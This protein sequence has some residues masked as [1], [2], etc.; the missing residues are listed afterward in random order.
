M[1]KI[2]VSPIQI[3]SDSSNLISSQV[4]ANRIVG[5]VSRAHKGAD[6]AVPTGTP[7]SAIGD[8]KVVFS[9]LHTSK[10]GPSH[11]FGNFVVVEHVINGQVYQSRYAHLSA[12]DVKVGDVV[13][14]GDV[15]GKSGGE[16]G[17]EA[18]GFSTGPHLHLELRKAKEGYNPL[19]KTSD[20]DKLNPND[21][22]DYKQFNLKQKVEKLDGQYELEFRG[23]LGVDD[24]SVLGDQLFIGDESISGT[25]T[26]L[27]DPNSPS[28]G[29]HTWKLTT[30]AYKKEYILTRLNE[31]NKPSITGTKLLISLIDQGLDVDGNKITTTENCVIINNFPFDLSFKSADEASLNNYDE[32]RT[33]IPAPFGIRLGYQKDHS[34]FT[35]NEDR[36]EFYPSNQ[37]LFLLNEQKIDGLV[38]PR[39][40]S[41][42]DNPENIFYSYLTY[43]FQTYDKDGLRVRHC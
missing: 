28:E 8:G 25:A 36:E 30:S 27:I 15:I 1:T 41:I 34:R 11:S 35:L 9:E 31:N 17:L 24:L 39:V 42:R 23:N 32:L 5:K 21:Y 22:I 2:F 38:I 20:Q 43:Q 18:S 37:S 13:K 3:N 19:G 4:A 6:Y 29:E 33:T 14:A 40:A 10:N 12:R 7:I 16:T 26:C